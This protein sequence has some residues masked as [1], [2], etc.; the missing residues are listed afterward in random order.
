MTKI[1]DPFLFA[2]TQ[3]IQEDEVAGVSALLNVHGISSSFW[4]ITIS[5]TVNVWSDCKV[6]WKVQ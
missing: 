6:G 2:K 5:A 4:H 3:M 1:F